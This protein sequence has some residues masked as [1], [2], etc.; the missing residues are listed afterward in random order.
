MDTIFH[1]EIEFGK[2][3]KFCSMTFPINGIETNGI[4]N[5]LQI[6]FGSAEE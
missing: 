2:P 6:T 4:T 3:I 1:S 5:F